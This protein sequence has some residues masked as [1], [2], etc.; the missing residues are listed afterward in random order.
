MLLLE[1][2]IIN[3]IE[4]QIK[5]I[6]VIVDLFIEVTCFR[7]TQRNRYLKRQLFTCIPTV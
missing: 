4:H 3:I 5:H 2:A 1:I 7:T 6:K